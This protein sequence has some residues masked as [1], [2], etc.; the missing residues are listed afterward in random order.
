MKFTRAELAENV[1]QATGLPVRQARAAVDAV[2]E[3]LAEALQAGLRVEL[4]GLFSARMAEAR[5]REI[6]LPGGRKT[7]VPARRKVRAKWLV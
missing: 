5:G 7:Q 2:C 6:I 4:R 1:A 3:S